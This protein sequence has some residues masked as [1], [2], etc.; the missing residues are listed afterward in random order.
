RTPNTIR[1]FSG[2]GSTYPELESLWVNQPYTIEARNRLGNW[3]Q[4]SHKEI[5]QTGWVLTGALMLESQELTLSELPV[6]ELPDAD[7]ENLA[8]SEFSEVP[9]LLHSTPILPESINIDLLREIYRDGQ[10]QGNDPYSVVKVGDC[11]TA[12]GFFLAPIST[13]Q[14]DPGPYDYITDTVG[15]YDESFGRRSLAARN[16]FNVSSIFDPFW[17]TDDACDPEESPLMCE[18][19]NNPASVA[20]IMFGQ[21]DVLVLNQEQYRDYLRQIVDETIDHGIIPVL[22]TFTNDPAN[23]DNWN[24]ILALNEITIEVAT[25]YDIPIINFWLAARDLPSYGI[26]DDYAHLTVSG[27]SID[28]SGGREANFGLT[29]YN[30]AVLSMLDTIYH[31]VIQVYTYENTRSS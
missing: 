3:V 17:A 31:D 14:F 27:G 13:A 16:G 12:S 9:E 8:N 7:M 2:P 5:D 28:F 1:L 10:E 6:S 26:A 19:R 20:F 15:R 24:Q 21:N 11:N 30:L 4:V 18:Y 22:S 23:A 29:L 25:E